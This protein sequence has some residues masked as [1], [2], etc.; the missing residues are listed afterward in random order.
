MSAQIPAKHLARIL[1]RYNKQALVGSDV[2][3]LI[4]RSRYVCNRSL[5]MRLSNDYLALNTSRTLLQSFRLY[6]VTYKLCTVHYHV[7]SHRYQTHVEIA[8]NH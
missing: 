5:Q 1:E 4:I 7:D 3:K 8:A 2:L 6:L